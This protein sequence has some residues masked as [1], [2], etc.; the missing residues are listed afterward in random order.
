MN[1]LLNIFEGI[2]KVWSADLEKSW[3]LIKSLK[4]IEAFYWIYIFLAL[5]YFIGY[6]S[7]KKILLVLNY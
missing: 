6:L 7:E 1:S 4:F 5:K 3:K 2:L